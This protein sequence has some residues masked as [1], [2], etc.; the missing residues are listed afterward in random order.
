MNKLTYYQPV[1][2]N[3]NLPEGF[4]SFCVYADKENLYRD[5]P[6]FIANEYHD[7]DIEEPD[8]VDKIIN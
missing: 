4:F 8:F 2:E 3:G 1:D 7:D 5:F 6:G